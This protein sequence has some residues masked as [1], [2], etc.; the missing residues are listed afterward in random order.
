MTPLE[1]AQCYLEMDVFLYPQE[2]TGPVSGKPGYTPPT[3]WQHVEASNY[4]L[5]ASAWE[6]GIWSDIYKR[7]KSKTTVKIR[8]VEGETVEKDLDQ[9]QLRRH[10]HPAFV[11]KGTPEDIQIA[12]QLVYRYHKTAFTLEEFVDK[13]FVGLDC[14]GFVGNYI[15][16]I[17]QHR[18]WE[19]ADPNHDPG[20]TTLIRDLLG[21]KGNRP[22]TAMKELVSPCIYLLGFCDDN[23]HIHDPSAAAPKDYGHIMMTNPGTLREAS[24]GLKIEVV[25]ATAAGNSK[26]RHLEYTI[27]DCRK[28]TKGTVFNIE[29]G[30]SAPSDKMTVRIA[31]LELS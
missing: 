23:G 30:S 16:R 12:I 31:E 14:N 20:P 2:L 28:A 19:T 17:M 29:R 15:Q 9:N 22:V 3:G 13:N 11:G 4:R 24:D 5:G 1:F 21:K 26:L 6:N 18:T 8:T 27:K 7:L 10:F 25:E